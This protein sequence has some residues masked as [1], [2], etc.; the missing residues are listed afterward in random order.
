NFTIRTEGWGSGWAGG[1]AVR[2]NTDSSLEPKWLVRTGLSG[3]GTVEDGEFHL[4]IR[5]HGHRGPPDSTAVG[6]PA[7]RRRPSRRR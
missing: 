2:V 5:R 1:N 4:Q 3:K 7:D 6:T